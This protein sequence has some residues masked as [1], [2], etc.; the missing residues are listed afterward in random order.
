MT[1]AHSAPYHEAWPCSESAPARDTDTGFCTPG[2]GPPSNSQGRPRH[3]GVQ[4]GRPLFHES[5]HQYSTPSTNDTVLSQALVCQGWGRSTKDAPSWEG[6]PVSL[7]GGGLNT[8]THTSILKTG[9]AGRQDCCKHQGTYRDSHTSPRPCKAG[10]KECL[11]EASHDGQRCPWP[12]TTGRPGW[13]VI[14]L[15]AGAKPPAPGSPSLHTSS[16]CCGFHVSSGQW[17][18]RR[19]GGCQQDGAPGPCNARTPGRRAG[20]CGGS[21]PSPGLLWEP[22]MPAH[23]QSLD[24]W[25]VRAS[26]W[27]KREVL[28][29]SEGIAAGS[30]D[31]RK[32]RKAPQERGLARLGHDY[33]R[34]DPYW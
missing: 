3:L 14:R 10:A 12:R 30:E 34:N 11:W 9:R 27:R 25:V 1:D 17:S 13:A 18:S 20:L 21:P 5:Q 23:G 24:N 15:K 6:V 32:D 22:P 28:A 7:W 26:I 33:S 2:G 16:G 19:P 31:G 29:G 8:S 4:E